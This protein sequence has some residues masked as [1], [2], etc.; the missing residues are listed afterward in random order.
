[1]TGSTSSQASQKAILHTLAALFFLAVA[2][3]LFRLPAL[4]NAAGANSDA[5]IVGLQAR[6]ILQGEW[7]WFLWGTNYQGIV[8]VLLTAIAFALV[9]PTPLT[10]LAVPLAG[11]V[12]V[13]WLTFAALRK[14]FELALALVLTLPLVLAPHP[15]NVVSLYPPRQWSITCIFVALWLL[16]R[17]N[18]SRQPML[19]YALGAALSVFSLYLDFFAVLFAPALA[20]FA[21]ACVFGGDSRRDHML[22]RFG[23]WLAGFALGGLLV[24]SIW[25]SVPAEALF[26]KKA[27]LSWNSIGD[28]VRLFRQQGFPWILSYNV[29]IPGREMYQLDLWQPP[30]GF[31]A[32]QRL[33]AA[34]FA[35]GVTFGGFALSLRNVPWPVRRLGVFGCSVTICTIIGFL[36]SPDTP[37]TGIWATRFLAPIIWTAPFALAPAAYVL[38]TK[39]FA[40][41]MTPYLIAAAVGGW[42]SFGPYVDGPTVVQAPRGV[43]KEEAQLGELLRRRGIHYA[44]ADYWFAYRLTF[45]WGEDPIVMPLIPPGEDR[46]LPYRR[47]F[48]RATEVAFI[49]HPYVRRTAPGPYARALT[50]AGIRHEQQRVGDFTIFF[51]HKR[52]CEPL[53]GHPSTC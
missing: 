25:Q 52:A 33:G 30:D 24:W 44:A 6:H 13:V 46:Y 48:D 53:P 12:L 8:D 7:S 21:M 20:L 32:V 42:L 51:V 23:A 9:G 5:T 16:S 34:L 31:R 50:E 43:A 36:A 18:R 39:R 22:K 10:L 3:V 28:N 4:I 40:L 11:H 41:G 14:E 17:A 29:F 37:T 1:M 49:F 26:T 47:G 45:L 35:L 15:I 2:S 19:H 38:G 27:Q